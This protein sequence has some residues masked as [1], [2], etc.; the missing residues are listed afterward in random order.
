[1]LLLLVVDREEEPDAHIFWLYCHSRDTI[2]GH[3]TNKKVQ[4]V[5][6]LNQ[7]PPI[8]EILQHVAFEKK[9]SRQLRHK[10]HQPTEYQSTQVNIIPSWLGASD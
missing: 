3:G 6:A 2:L 10:W 1:M 5:V 7:T 4:A 9:M 8:L